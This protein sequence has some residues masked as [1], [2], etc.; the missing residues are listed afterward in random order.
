MF[1]RLVEIT[2][3]MDVEVT[4]RRNAQLGEDCQLVLHID[5]QSKQLEHDVKASSLFYLADVVM[6]EDGVQRIRSLIN[7]FCNSFKK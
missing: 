6:A 7:K 2:N 1:M 5:F 3:L 4:V